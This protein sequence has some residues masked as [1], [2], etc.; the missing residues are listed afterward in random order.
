LPVWGGGVRIF[1]SFNSKDV[2]LAEA[3][4]VG[5]SRL[6]PD[7]NIFFSPISLGSGL[8]LPKLADEIT[9]AD[10]FLLLIGP[11]GVG[12][13]QK[14]EYFTA[15]DRH[16]NDKGFALVPV[17]AAGAQELGVPASIIGKM[18]VTPPGQIVWLTPDD[19]RS[20][21]TILTGSPTQTSV[22]RQAPM[23]S[24][25][26]SSSEIP[27]ASE[28]NERMTWKAFIAAAISISADQHGGEPDLDRVCRPELNLCN[29]VVSFEYEGREVIV[30]VTEDALGNSV[31]R[32]TCPLND[33]HD[34]RTCVNWDTGAKAR[35]MKNDNGEWIAIRN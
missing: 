35:A 6:E 28:S 21:G 7:A 23:Q 3:I 26:Y 15:F 17:I 33:F 29:T 32:E 20:M 14:I 5:L 18:V 4:R 1:L 24:E 31:E 16:V 34:V 22:S 27:S 2:A 8:W 11:Q 13:W 30:R 10:A 9:E 19:L 12:P 25:P